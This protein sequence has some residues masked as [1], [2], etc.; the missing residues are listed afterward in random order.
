MLTAKGAKPTWGAG[1]GADAYM[2]KPFS[3]RELVQKVAELL[4][5]RRHEKTDPRLLW[6]I[7]ASGLVMALWLVLMSVIVWSTL[8]QDERAAVGDVL[9]SRTALVAVGWL[10][11]LVLVAGVLRVCTAATWVHLT[12]C[13]KK[14]AWCCPPP[15]RRSSNPGARPKC[16]PWPMR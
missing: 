2:T 15:R 13:W 5:R 6:A 9:A 16:R 11:G 12:V 3:T 1:P 7:A 10:I 4:G 14:P 8:T